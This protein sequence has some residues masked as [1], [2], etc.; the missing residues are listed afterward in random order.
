MSLFKENPKDPITLTR[1]KHS[2]SSRSST[3]RITTANMSLPTTGADS[4]CGYGC[5]SFL[6]IPSGISC[7]GSDPGADFK[8]EARFVSQLINSTVEPR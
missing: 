5:L 7:I 6:M 4:C 2:D 1:L 8:P 3:T